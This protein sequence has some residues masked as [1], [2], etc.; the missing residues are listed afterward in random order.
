MLFHTKRVIPKLCLAQ[1]RRLESDLISQIHSSNKTYQT[2]QIIINSTLYVVSAYL[3]S[4]VL[5]D[6]NH[7]L[8]VVPGEGHPARHQ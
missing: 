7:S 3:Q 1:S 6:G 8:N 2:H 5:F 4:C